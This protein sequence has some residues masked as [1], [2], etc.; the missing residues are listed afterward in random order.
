[1]R[2]H[3]GEVAG[4][5]VVD[6]VLVISGGRDALRYG[7]SLATT[8]SQ[9]RRRRADLL[10]PAGR[11]CGCWPTSTFHFSGIVVGRFGGD[12]GARAIGADADVGF[13]WSGGGDGASRAQPA[14]GSSTTDRKICR[15][16]RG[17][18]GEAGF[19]DAEYP[20]W[21]GLFAPAKTSST[22]LDE[23]H[24]QTLKALQVPKVRGKLAALGVDPMVMTRVQFAEYIHKQSDA[25]AALVKAIGLKPE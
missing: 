8:R 25:N 10:E 4:G 23:L 14:T 1:L 19:A 5:A 6:F 13:A 7:V 21:F 17:T 22:T 11:R 16:D 12:D 24:D 15:T 20:I 18:T 3:D 2:P 9:Q